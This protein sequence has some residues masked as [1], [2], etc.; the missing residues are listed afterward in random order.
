MRATTAALLSVVILLLASLALTGCVTTTAD[1]LQLQPLA[2][3]AQENPAAA[4]GIDPASYVVLD[5]E[6]HGGI[7]GVAE[8]ARLFLDGHVLLERRGQDPATFQLSP[9]EQTQLNA[10]LDAAD[11]YRNAAQTAPPPP[12]V[13]DAFQYRI[14]RRGVLLQGQVETH[15]GAVPAWLEPLLPL[16]TNLLLNPDPARVQ[17]LP[18][19]TAVLTATAPLTETVAAPSDAPS[20]VVM[21]FVRSQAGADVRVLI[22]LDRGYSVAGAGGVVEGTLT[23]A[24]MAALTRLLESADLRAHAGDYTPAQPCPTCATYAVTYRNLLSSATVRGEEGALPDWFQPVARAFEKQFITAELAAA[25]ATPL[26]PGVATTVT[27]TITDTVAVLTATPSAA[28]A[29]PVAAAPAADQAYTALALLA[30]LANAGA[31]VEAA[32]GRITKPYLSAPGMIARVNGLPVQLFEYA[33]AAALAADVAGLAPN[34]SSVDG[35]PL[36]WAAAPHFW[37]Q[38]GLLALAVSDDQALVDLISRVMGPQFAGR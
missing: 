9:A 32:P 17:P 13:P 38:G 23:R 20:I 8:R 27:A 18:P 34:A 3:G 22:N 31:L 1:G 29:T 21:E 5:L 24:E 30:D 28:T 36:V 14:Q 33:D 6:R 7:A 19:A 15:D 4:L 25:L 35:V 2:G 16:L 26:A 10:A 37:R 11:F 12:V